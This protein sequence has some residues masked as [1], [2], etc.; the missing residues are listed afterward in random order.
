MMNHIGPLSLCLLTILTPPVTV[1]YDGKVNIT[2]DIHTVTC[3]VTTSDLKVTLG[4]V[5]STAF[6][7]SGDSSDLIPFSLGVKDCSAVSNVTVTFTGIAA[8]K[9]SPLV[10]LD[11]APGTATG[12]GVKILDDTKSTI[13]VNS[14]SHSYPVKA[15][16]TTATL[17]F[18][19][20][21]TS[22][23]T[24]V[25]AGPASATVTFNMTYE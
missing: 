23:S 12:L 8:V 4:E 1:A 7:A 9:G 10:A 11:S 5:Y 18:Y 25:T 13:A 24:K 3:A 15:G 17:N 19:A 21:F 14:T 6:T 16:A 2:G 22:Y 20:Q